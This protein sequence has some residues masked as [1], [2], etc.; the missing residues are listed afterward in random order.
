MSDDKK[1]TT[2]EFLRERYEM[3]CKTIK[4]WIE[5]NDSE[6][7]R[8]LLRLRDKIGDKCNEDDPEDEQENMKQYML[9]LKMIALYKEFNEKLFLAIEVTKSLQ[10]NE[11]MGELR[12][13]GM[14]DEAF[15]I[16]IL[17]WLRDT[18]E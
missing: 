7:N 14:T 10:G 18:A 1:Q 13:P 12:K 9:E 16:V 2:S 3:R 8:N 15:E 5:V 17:E 6:Y 4:E 11:E